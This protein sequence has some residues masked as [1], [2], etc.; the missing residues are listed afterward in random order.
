M[1]LMSHYKVIIA[2]FFF[3]GFSGLLFEIVWCRLILRALGAG[4]VANS[5]VFAGFMA[6]AAVGAIVGWKNPEFLKILG[7]P[8]KAE[9]ISTTDGKNSALFARAYGRLELIAAVSGLVIT[10]LLNAAVCEFVASLLAGLAN[11]EALCNAIRFLICFVILLLPCSAM[12]AA[13]AT[14]EKSFAAKQASTNF[15][16]L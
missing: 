4:S 10:W 5:C 2:L 3:S 7:R 1:W 8:F 6:G 15:F 12:G 13:Y 11:T 9:S 14:I 16:P